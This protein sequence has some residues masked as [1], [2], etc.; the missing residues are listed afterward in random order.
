MTGCEIKRND[1]AWRLQRIL[2]TGSEPV[3]A[4]KAPHPHRLPSQQQTKPAMNPPGQCGV[5]KPLKSDVY[6]EA[7]LHS[8]NWA[9]QPSWGGLYERIASTVLLRSSSEALAFTNFA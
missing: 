9:D 1:G 6:S 2:E 8:R 3:E 5:I 4:I 7:P